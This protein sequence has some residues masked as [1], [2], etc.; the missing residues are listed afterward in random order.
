[1]ESILYNVVYRSIKYPR[2]GKWIKDKRAIIAK[3]LE[4]A[5]TKD[6]I[7]KRDEEFKKI[8]G[9]KVKVFEKELST[10]VNKTF[11]KKMRPKW[12]SCSIK[13]NITVNV[14]AKYLP[15]E[16]IEYILYHEVAHTIERRHSKIFWNIIGKR[17][18]D[19]KSREKELLTYWFT[20]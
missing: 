20:I 7:E 12:A 5:K 3:A 16:T 15:E 18:Q 8:V 17:F 13:D 1:V 2:Y 6:I 10:K 9:E 4:D 11:F 14:L 19:Y